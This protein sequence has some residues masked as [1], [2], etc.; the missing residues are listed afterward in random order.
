M[1]SINHLIDFVHKK[2]Q[3]TW[4]HAFVLIDAPATTFS[5]GRNFDVYTALIVTIRASKGGLRGIHEQRGQSLLQFSGHIKLIHSH[6]GK[7]KFCDEI[8]VGYVFI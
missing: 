2:M 3:V 6:W 4:H 1:D 7:I 8:R 5:V